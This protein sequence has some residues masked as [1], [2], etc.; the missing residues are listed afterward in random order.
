MD[1]RHVIWAQH[2]RQSRFKSVYAGVQTALA[3]KFQV[4]RV[5]G[6]AFSRILVEDSCEDYEDCEKKMS[7]T[8]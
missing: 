7:Y 1:A 6:A 3:K 4:L 5:S 8:L 2:A